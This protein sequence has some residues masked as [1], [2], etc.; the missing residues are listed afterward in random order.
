VKSFPFYKNIEQHESLVNPESELMCYSFEHLNTL[1]FLIS[2]LLLSSKYKYCK[3]HVFVSPLCCPTFRLSWLITGY[4][5]RETRRVQLVKQELYVFYILCC[6]SWLIYYFSWYLLYYYRLNINIVKFIC[7][8][9][10]MC[11]H[12]LFIFL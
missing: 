2:S 10:I 4:L 12:F 6:G 7:I 11:Y 9:V 5:I 1:F 8:I 3:V